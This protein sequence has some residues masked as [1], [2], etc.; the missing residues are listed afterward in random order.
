MLRLGKPYTPQVLP[1]GET[2]PVFFC[3]KSVD[4]EDTVLTWRKSMECEGKFGISFEP[5]W[6]FVNGRK[7]NDAEN[8][9]MKLKCLFNKDMETAKR[10]MGS[11][12]EKAFLALAKGCKD[13]KEWQKTIYNGLKKDLFAVVDIYPPSSDP[14]SLRKKENPD[15]LSFEDRLNL[16]APT[17][18]EKAKLGSVNTAQYKDEYGQVYFTTPEGKRQAVPVYYSNSTKIKAGSPTAP[19]VFPWVVYYEE[20]KYESVVAKLEEC[21]VDLEFISG[22]QEKKRK[23]A[24]AAAAAAAS[25][26]KAESSS[27]SSSSSSSSDDEDEGDDDFAKTKDD[28][29]KKEKE[30]D[31]DD[32]DEDLF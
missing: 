15:G 32:D 2:A 13:P 5:A 25:K 7:P 1:E 14:D 8:P 17:R 21:S 20:E 24:E 11:E 31:D 12:K 19:S 27:A 26:K 22:I 30:E 4:L 16:E 10:V 28:E 18:I 23:K 6:L 3:R 29:K 9:E